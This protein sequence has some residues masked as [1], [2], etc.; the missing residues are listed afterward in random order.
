[1]GVNIVFLGV[2]RMGW[3]AAFFIFVLGLAGC[4]GVKPHPVGNFAQYAETPRLHVSAAF[5]PD[6]RLWRVVATH[7]FVY[8][9]WSKDQGQTFSAPVQ[10]NSQAQHIQT[11]DED[12]PQIVVD[13]SGHVYVGYSA[14]STLPWTIW[15]SMSRDGGEH[16]SVPVLL[17]DKAKEAR[18]YQLKLAVSPTDRLYAFW[19]DDR[20]NPDGS[21]GAGN[22]LY[23][24]TAQQPAG[25]DG[26]VNQK[27]LGGQCECCRVAVAFDGEAQPLM[28]ARFVYPGSIRDHGLLRSRGNGKEW[29][30]W[31]VTFDDWRIEAC[32]EHGPAFTISGEGGYH[33]AWFT[34]GPIRQGL[35]YARSMD[36][37]QHFSAPVSFG[38]LNRLPSHPD[39][40][41][42]GNR[43]V[44]TWREFDGASTTVSVMQSQDGG[45]SWSAAKL[46]AQTAGEAD[47]P[48]LLSNGQA[49][50][51]SWNTQA[52]GYRLM[53]L[54]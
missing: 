46:L 38:D 48:F 1:M 27:L 51:L 49:I 44:L 7:Q 9:D 30:N 4:S 40:I 20:A 28:L 13:R 31:R 32:P 12:R 23:F 25:L 36:R 42:L 21:K 53:R 10:V 22:E 43:V 29:S 39:V 47:F 24:A 2:V 52:E 26:L 54:D 37:G 18:H 34:Q 45:Q 6:G 16:F 35:F 5:G 14:Y 3:R 19:H 11:K 15:V 8:V 50:F 33:M 41:V 17:S